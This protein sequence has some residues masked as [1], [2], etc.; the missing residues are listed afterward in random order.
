MINEFF[1]YF[2]SN[3]ATSINMLD[4][5]STGDAHN[6]TSQISQDSACV[7]S[8]NIERLEDS[9]H[10]LPISSSS[11]SSNQKSNVELRDSM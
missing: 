4:S 6:F 5:P 8:F 11:P 7:N 3:A 10:S 9:D 2:S 1:Y